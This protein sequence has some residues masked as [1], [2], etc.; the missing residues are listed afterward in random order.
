MGESSAWQTGLTDRE[1]AIQ[2][3]FSSFMFQADRQQTPWAEW[4][5]D[6]DQLGVTSLRY[7]IAFAG[8]GCAAMAAKTPAYHE[9]VGKQLDDLCQRLIDVRTWFYVTKYWGKQYG[10][11][12]PDPCQYENVMYTGHLTLGLCLY[13]LFTGDLRY[14]EAGWDFVWRDGRKLHY[15]LGKAV[16]HLRDLSKASPSGGICCEPGLVFAMCNDHSAISLQ[17]FD[18]VHKT[19]YA[20]VNARWFAWM[21]KNFRSRIP[22]STCFLYS[23]YSERAKMFLPVSDVGGDAWTL[24]WGYPWFPKTDLAKEGWEYLLKHAQWKS[25]ADDQLYAEG[26]AVAG[27]CGGKKTFVRNAFLPLLAVQVE[28]ADSPSAKKMLNWL[29]VNFGRGIDT[30]GDG[31]DDGYCY[32]I[33]QS[34][35][36]PATGNIASTL[37]TDGLSLRKLYTTPRMEILASP[38]LEHV[39]YPNIYVRTAEYVKPVLRFT[40][41]KG[42]PGFQGKTELTCSKISGKCTITRDG[43]PF[44]DY[45]QEGDK[46]ILTTDVDREHV[47]ELKMSP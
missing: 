12:F 27:C 33:E 37:A 18:L 25:P 36:V 22:N 11:G 21:A 24:G 26:N 41:L 1:L 34:L 30:D 5:D 16:E 2:R 8:Y 9:V 39:D 46:V 47:F 3:W 42:K 19:H 32:D 23:V 13:E 44:A 40:I 7:Q 15:T 45:R 17:L 28:G 35:R 4:Y 31:H 20:D 6:N 10:D 43:Q 38:T 14:S 29:E